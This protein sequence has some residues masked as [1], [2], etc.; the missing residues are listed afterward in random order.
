MGLQI[1][2]GSSLGLGASEVQMVHRG[3][4][5]FGFELC[6]LFLCIS[7]FLAFCPFF[8]DEQ[9]FAN[10]LFLAIYYYYFLSRDGA[11]R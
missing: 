11:V 5:G 4:L 1:V 6:F 8:I 9:K 2:G 7:N 10:A 3:G